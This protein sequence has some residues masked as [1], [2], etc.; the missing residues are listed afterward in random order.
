M[1]KRLSPTV[2]FMLSFAIFCLPPM[3]LL[4]VFDLLVGVL[5]VLPLALMIVCFF[6]AAMLERSCYEDYKTY[7]LE[8]KSFNDVQDKLSKFDGIWMPIVCVL[9]LISLVIFLVFGFPIIGYFFIMLFGGEVVDHIDTVLAEKL[10]AFVT[11]VE[12]R[13]V[14]ICFVALLVGAISVPSIFMSIRSF[15]HAKITSSLSFHDSHVNFVSMFL[16]SFLLALF[17]CYL[18]VNSVLAKPS[19]V[20]GVVA[21]PSGAFY[22]Y[23]MFWFLMVGQLFL[24]A[25]YFQ[26]IDRAI[27]TREGEAP[28]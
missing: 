20:A 12:P 3:A 14:V 28:A 21:T 27:K 4:S 17:V 9:L 5:E 26:R 11:Y 13:T 16:G 6:R 8:G 7:F 23:I 1:F 19:E 25:D 22:F 24:G 15:R 10:D 2:D 18:G